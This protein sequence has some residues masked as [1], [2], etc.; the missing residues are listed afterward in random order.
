MCIRD[1]D[2]VGT[3]LVEGD[4]ISITYDDA[5]GNDI[6][7][8]V[9]GLDHAD[10]SDF[11]DAVTEIISTGTSTTATNVTATANNSTNET[12]YVTFVDGPTSSQGIETDTSLT[13]NPSTN[14]LTAGTF[15]GAIANSNV[16][17]LEEKIE[18]T[19]DGLLVDGDKIEITYD[20]VAQR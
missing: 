1:R 19:V 14:T 6:T 17:N 11:D 2:I 12:V 20:D 15:D 13:Y 16:T 9:N 7:I 4:N 5:T 3:G 10:I 8:A 18:D